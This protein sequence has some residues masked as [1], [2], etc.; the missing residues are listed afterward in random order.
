MLPVS[1]RALIIGLAGPALQALG[2]LWT[3]LHL[4][5]AHWSDTFGPR[6]LI[7]EPGVLLII[8]G[9]AVS[10]ICVPVAME[11]ARAA[12]DEIEIP[13]YSPGPATGGGGDGGGILRPE[14]GRL[15]RYSPGI[16]H[17]A[18]GQDRQTQSPG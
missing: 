6:H 10:M 15:A 16:G 7:Y 5:L 12:E 1:K 13:V 9:F 14:L 2:L 17:P 18:T 11:V 8:V 4:L 3:A